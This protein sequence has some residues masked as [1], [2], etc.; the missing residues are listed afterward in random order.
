MAV[1]K[2]KISPQKEKN[3]SLENSCECIVR[4]FEW[5]ALSGSWDSSGITLSNLLFCK[6]VIHCYYLWF[7][8]RTWLFKT[9]DKVITLTFD[10]PV[11]VLV[12]KVR[13]SYRTWR[14]Q[15]LK[16]WNCLH[17]KKAQE[18]HTYK[19]RVTGYIMQFKN[20]NSESLRI[21]CAT[22]LLC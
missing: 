13:K 6:L 22:A 5:T 17:T 15:R 2:K 11:Q 14:T 4:C 19:K 9:G 20:D 18:K 8:W 16:V 1:A 12:K 7:T 3:L 10:I 21:N